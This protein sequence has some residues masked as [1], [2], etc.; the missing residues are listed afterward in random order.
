VHFNIFKGT[1]AWKLNV[2]KA[3]IPKPPTGTAL[4]WMLVEAHRA[5]IQSR[6]C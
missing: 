4:K 2:S 3:L 6:A 1:P 5:K